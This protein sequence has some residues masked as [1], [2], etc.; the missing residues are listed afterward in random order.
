MSPLATFAMAVPI[1]PMPKAAAATASIS[2]LGERV[3]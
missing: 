1:T 3:G 2:P